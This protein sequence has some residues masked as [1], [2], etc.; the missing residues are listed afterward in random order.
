MPEITR[1]SSTRATARVSVGG[2]DA[3]RP[4]CSPLSQNS[5]AMSVLLGLWTG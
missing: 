3:N 5:L 4:K 1:L 2:S